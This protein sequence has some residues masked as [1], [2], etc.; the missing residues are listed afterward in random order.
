MS[1]PRPLGDED[2]YADYMEYLRKENIPGMTEA[3]LLEQT[4]CHVLGLMF[5]GHE[6]AACTMLFAV[7]YVL[8]DRSVL[9]ELRV[10]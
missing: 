2:Q 1:K 7:K 10:R 6:T 3:L 5:A 4:R 8:K 9:K